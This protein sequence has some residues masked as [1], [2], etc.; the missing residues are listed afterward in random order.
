MS[1]SM[2]RGWQK[3]WAPGGWR[4]GYSGDLGAQTVAPKWLLLV[5][6]QVTMVSVL[7]SK[8]KGFLLGEF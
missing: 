7:F 6:W 8:S 5:V 1:K 4:L 2:K 3:T